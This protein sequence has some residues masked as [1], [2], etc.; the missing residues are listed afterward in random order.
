MTRR[1]D[2]CLL[3][4][5]ALTTA[6]SLADDVTLMPVADATL[7]EDSQGSRA[8]GAGQFLFIGQTS[9]PENRRA[10]LRFDV[11]SLPADATI[12]S[13]SLRLTMS[14]TISTGRTAT[15]HRVLA[16][17]GE[18]SSN[19]GGQEGNGTSSATD[20][21]TWIHTFFDQQTWASAGGDFDASAS[22]TQTVSGNGAYTWQSDGLIADVQ[23]WIAEPD[24]NFGWLLLGDE[25]AQ[26]TAKRFDS[27]EHPTAAN[28]PQLTIEFDVPV[29]NQPP[30]VAAQPSGFRGYV[31]T[32]ATTVVVVADVFND[33]DGDSLSYSVSVADSAIA[34]PILSTG[35]GV[36][37]VS[38]GQT[39]ITLTATDPSGE[40]ASVD[41]SAEV[42]AIPGDF[43]W[44]G[45]VDFDDFFRFGDHF[46]RSQTDA[47]FDA[48]FDL[49]ADGTIGFDDFFLFGDNFGLT[50]ADDPLGLL[51]DG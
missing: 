37:G 51:T 8:N 36:D 13:V 7:F 49:V 18:G 46:G 29:T 1:T 17:W 48:T 5:F 12:T 6:P 2:L 44:N 23:R 27:R 28:R 25:S 30:V 14:R 35:L 45:T 43:D 50:T 11:S 38:P 31:G 34:V 10:V 15:L 19:A 32:G 40:S 39:T 41:I 26:R 47:D 33:A 9:Q 24:S 21:A 16:D 22:A 20:D 4:M 42:L 3:L